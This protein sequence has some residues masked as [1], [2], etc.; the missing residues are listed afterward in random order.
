MNNNFKYDLKMFIHDFD[1]T[2]FTIGFLEIRWYSLSY[3][4]GIIFGWYLGKKYLKKIF[5]TNNIINQ[6][7]ND[8]FDDLITYIIIAI[9]LGGRLGYIIFYDLTYYLNSPTSMLKIWEGG[10]SFHG[11]LIGIIITCYIFSKKHG[12]NFFHLSDV[13]ACVAPIGLFFGRVANF[14]N[15][16]LYGYPTKQSWGVVFPT[17]DDQPRH[18]SQLY[19]ALLEGLLL[20]LILNIV[21]K[22][23]RYKEGKCSYLFLFFYGFFR[24]ISE[25]FR[26]PDEQIGLLFNSLSMGSLLSIL[27]IIF[28]LIIFKKTQ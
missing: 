6:N 2:I 5:N 8:I 4:F 28:S 10:M 7:S 11:A 14:I 27:M 20:F 3:I 23:Y 17:V 21:F 16:E 13:V 12:L 24:I 9:I 19:E 25:I 15:S 1:P 26:Q 18:P 22:F